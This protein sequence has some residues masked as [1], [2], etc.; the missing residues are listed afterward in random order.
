M[1][2]LLICNLST[3]N[4]KLQA[5]T[6]FVIE[7]LTYIHTCIKL[8]VNSVTDNWASSVTL[9]YQ[10]IFTVVFVMSQ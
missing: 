1:I 8:Y 9:I 10:K 7:D 5:Y 3:N 6:S 2:Y 4:Y